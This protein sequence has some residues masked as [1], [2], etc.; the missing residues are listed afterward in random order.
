M[1][2]TASSTIYEK[3]VIKKGDREVNLVGKT[4]GFT[5]YESLLSPNVTAL[6]TFMDAGGAITP[7]KDY[8]RQ[9]NKL[10]SIYNGLPIT[11]GERIIF[12][13]GALD[14]TKIPFVVNGVIQPSQDSN[15]EVI[16][17]SLVSESACLNQESSVYKKHTG[18]I[19]DTVQKLINQYLPNMKVGTLENTSNSYNFIGNSKNVFDLI[20]SLASKSVPTIG[21]PGFFFYETRDGLQ[22]KSINSLISQDAVNKGT[23]FFRTDALR[24]GVAD[25]QNNYKINKFS[26]N[27][28]QN[29]IN[30]LKSGVYYSKNIF[31]NPEN[32]NYEQVI[33]KLGDK[34]LEKSLGKEPPIPEPCGNNKNTVHTR[35]HYHVLDI[36]TLV[37]PDNKDPNNDP[38]RWQATATTRYNLLFTQV[39]HLQIPYNDALRAGDTIECNFEIISDRKEQ[40]SS[41]PVQ[42]GKYLIM[43]LC[44]SFDSTNSFTSMTLVRDTY[45]LY[46]NKNKA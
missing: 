46:T 21:E 5:Y 4:V 27:K 1:A 17:L 38:K 12:K 45:G 44:H 8:D 26:V 20:C 40:G 36:G 14:F 2:N 43:D 25:D 11:G 9:D 28:N 23:P 18:N 31:F 10:T 32:F 42:S 41:D 29:L 24:S 19:K 3:L 37:K 7:N 16:A 30:A 33:Y 34:G 22:F 13:K 6:L 15:R 39:V 35:T